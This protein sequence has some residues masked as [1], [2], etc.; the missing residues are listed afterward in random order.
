M[1]SPRLSYRNKSPNSVLSKDPF[2]C[3]S[4]VGLCPGCIDTGLLPPPLLPLLLFEEAGVSRC[5]FEDSSSF[6]RCSNLVSP[7]RDI[8]R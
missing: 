2:L 6:Q 4:V 8:P 3:F 1:S 7:T 5:T